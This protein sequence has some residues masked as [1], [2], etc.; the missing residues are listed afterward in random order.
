MRRGPK[1]LGTVYRESDP[2]R[3]TI[4]RAEKYVTLPDGTSKRIVTRGKTEREALQKRNAKEAALKRAHPDAERQTAGQYL[5]A[6]VESKKRHGLKVGSIREYQRIVKHTVA[7][8]GDVP[9]SR[10]TP[11]HVQKVMDAHVPATANA[12]LRYL[13]TAFR[14]AER[15]ELIAANPARNLKPVKRDPPRRG[16]WN[17]RQIRAFLRSETKPVPRAMFTLAIYGGLRRGELMALPW[18]N[19]T[20]GGVL[21]DRTWSRGGTV[22]TPKTNAA[23]RTVPIHRVVYERIRDARDGIDS[24][25]AFPTRNGTMY[26]GG[27]L[28]RTWRA[29][30]ARSGVKPIR[31][32]DMRRTAATLWAKAGHPPKVIQRLLGHS[33]VHVAL[34]AYNDV[35]ESQLAHAAL[36]PS[37]MVVRVGVRKSRIR[38]Q[39]RIF[40]TKP[41]RR[42]IGPKAQN[43][44]P[45]PVA[46]GIEQPP[47]KSQ[48][49]KRKK[50]KRTR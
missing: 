35:L 4:W 42:V 3:G 23:Y 33:T 19:V 48:I 34:A 38:G 30:L 39:T 31:F 26:G 10:V 6:W 18:A 1:G 25:L 46:Q 32:H 36:D 11:R 40:G 17:E 41:K 12:I 15:L 45:A 13:R 44:V 2:K 20:P 5:T 27:N 28:G 7:V 16:V 9:L 21:V 8:I 49:N 37:A 22:T 47:S 24:D 29:N 14:Q 50:P 43:R